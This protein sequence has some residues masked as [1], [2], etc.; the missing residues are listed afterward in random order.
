M[1]VLIE[2]LTHI[3]TNNKVMS[4]CNILKITDRI[5]TNRIVFYMIRFDYINL[6]LSTLLLAKNI[7]DIMEKHYRV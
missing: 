4:T 6:E 2:V 3:I 1:L 7:S 5:F